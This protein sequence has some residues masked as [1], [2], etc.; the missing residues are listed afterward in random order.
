MSL[1]FLFGATMSGITVVLLS[2]PRTS[3]DS[4]WRLNPRAHETFTSMGKSAIL[5]MVAV[6]VACMCAAIGLWLQA[7]WG[8]IAAVL[9][10]V[11]NLCG[12]LFNA[13][14]G[15]DWHTL[16]GVLIA[17]TMIFYLASDRR[18]LTQLQRARK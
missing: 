4:L 12:D 6:C 14:V 9:L 7:R 10:L 8:Y 15:H 13:L 11:V 16:I 2:F 17:A 5:L 18:R 1:F 3:L